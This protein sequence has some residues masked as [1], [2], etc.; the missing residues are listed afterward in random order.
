MGRHAAMI[1]ATLGVIGLY[2][3]SRQWEAF[4]G[5]YHHVFTLAGALSLGLVTIL[6]KALHEC[7]HAFVATRFGCRVPTV[8]VAFMVMVPL[9]YT[10]VTDAWRLGDRRARMIID[11]A[12]IAVEIALACLALFAW[13]FLPE[14]PAKTAAFMVATASLIMTLGLNL[15]P[16]MRF[17]GYYLLADLWRVENLQPRAFALGR[18]RLRELL[19]AAGEPCPE[20]MSRRRLR[21][22]AAY[23]WSTWAYRLI[24]FTGIALL[25]YHMFFKAL[26]I[27]LFLVEIVFFIALPVVRELN[28]WWRLRGHLWR[29]RRAAATGLAAVMLVGALFVPWPVRIDIPAVLEWRDPVRLFPVRAARVASVEVVQGQDLPAGAILVTLDVPE[30]VSQMALTRTRLAVTRLRLARRMADDEDRQQSLVL[31]D[32][33]RALASRLQGLEQEQALLTVRTPVP[34]RLLELNPGLH[35]GR[36][37]AKTEPVAMVGKPGQWIMRGY[38]GEADLQRVAPGARGSFIAHESLLPPIDVELIEIAQAGAPSIEL[39]ELM[40]PHGGAIAVEEDRA[41]R[42]VPVSAQYL[43]TLAPRSRIPPID[44][45]VRGTAVLEGAPESQAARAWRHVLA[46]FVRETGF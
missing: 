8:G 19:F 41:R 38:A 17:D 28:A 11:A 46:V 45:V 33:L 2:L 44:R 37:I 18:W 39:P 26:G 16:F 14:G 20:V 13:P 1:I 40:S 31:E 6:V 10:D 23:A 29:T 5:T 27:V 36:W 7:G 21:L 9:L 3:V 22:L 35:P 15:N 34:G 12:G 42:P 43:A 24:T 30:L 25:V 4:L 32:E